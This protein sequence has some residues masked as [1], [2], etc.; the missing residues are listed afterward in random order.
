VKFLIVTHVVHTQ[1]GNDFFAYSPYVNEMNVWLR[2]VNS[3]TIIAPLKKDV[4]TQLQQKYV[5][6]SIKFIPVPEFSFI[7]GK[8]SFKAIFSIPIIIWKL[9]GAMFSAEHIHLRCPGNMGLL[10]SLVQLFFPFKCKSA[11][12]AGNWDPQSSQ[13]LSYQLQKFILRN[14]L[15]TKRMQVLVYGKWNNFTK[16]CKS[17]FTATYADTETFPLQTKIWEDKIKFVFVGNLVSG[18]Q[19]LK[20]IQIIENLIPH[21]PNVELFIYGDGPEREKLEAY[22]IKESLQMKVFLK[23]AQDKET[24]K[25]VYQNSHF[26]ILFSKSEGWPKVVAEAMFW[27]CLPIASSVSCVPNMLDYGKRGIILNDSLVESCKLITKL[28]E[29]KSDY[30]KRRIAA[31]SWSRGFTIEKFEKELIKILRPCE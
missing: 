31:I 30:E 20:A 22:I 16:N 6:K 4:V 15:L 19:P 23:G 25:Q 13:P 3:V 12:Y 7:N 5:S 26:L 17:F 24:L 18:K 27:G 8:E 1:K 11:K 28:I 29:D 2:H 9:F 10:G 21:F 14:T